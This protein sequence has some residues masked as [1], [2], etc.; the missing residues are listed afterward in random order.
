MWFGNPAPDGISYGKLL[1]CMAYLKNIIIIIFEHIF[2]ATWDWKCTSRRFVCLC[3]VAVLG[4]ISAIEKYQIMFRTC[5]CATWG[6]KRT[7]RWCPS[8]T[9][10]SRRQ[11]SSS[12]A[13]PSGTT[14]CLL[15]LFT[16]FHRREN[17]SQQHLNADYCCKFNIC[18]YNDKY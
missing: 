2:F 9:P 12:C 7:A 14:R 18:H 6:R 15:L 13:T 3:D 1:A 8:P 11:S 4:K 16:N 17:F 5:C 10:P